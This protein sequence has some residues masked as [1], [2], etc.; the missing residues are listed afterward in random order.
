MGDSTGIL[1]LLTGHMASLLPTTSEWPSD[2]RPH[3]ITIPV[4]LGAIY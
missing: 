1:M 3:R 2:L 4:S